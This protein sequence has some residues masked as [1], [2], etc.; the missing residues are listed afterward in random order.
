[1]IVSGRTRERTRDTHNDRDINPSARN[2][3]D[4]ANVNQQFAR[5][6]IGRHP[7]VSL[8]AAM[9]VGA[10]LGWAIKRR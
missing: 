7:A 1:M 2:T 4:D 10:L 8:G 5:T 3:V 9:V 6:W